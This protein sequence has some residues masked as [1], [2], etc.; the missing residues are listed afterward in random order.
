MAVQG[1]PDGEPTIYFFRD[2][3]VFWFS[4]AKVENYTQKLPSSGLI[5]VD[6]HVI[7]IGQGAADLEFEGPGLVAL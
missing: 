6:I 5:S 2:R 1:L 3:V 4:G 7:R